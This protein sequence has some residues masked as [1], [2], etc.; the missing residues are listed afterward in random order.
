M[1][2][3]K[4]APDYGKFVFGFE[5]IDYQSE[6]TMTKNVGA[7]LGDF[8]LNPELGN[9]EYFGIYNGNAVPVSCTDP[10]VP[11]S[12]LDWLL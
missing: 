1:K 3:A 8:W 10:N 5:T 7:Y 11:L 2:T 6:S 12:F 4:N 9:V